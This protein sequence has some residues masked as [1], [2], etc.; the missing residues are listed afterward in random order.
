M[1]FIHCGPDYRE[2]C[3]G[4]AVA[5]AAVAATAAGTTSNYYNCD[6]AAEAEYFMN[7]LIQKRGSS[8]SLSCSG[9]EDHCVDSWNG[10]GNNGSNAAVDD[11]RDYWDGKYEDMMIT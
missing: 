9:E 6:A 11:G 1:P 2:G 8:S 7:Q 3:G 5:V 10:K 4:G